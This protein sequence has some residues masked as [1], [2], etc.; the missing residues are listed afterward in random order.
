MIKK[1]NYIFDKIISATSGYE[2]LDI[3]NNQKIDILITDIMMPDFDGLSLSLHAKEKQPAIQIIFITGHSNFEFAKEGINL[4]VLG[5]IVKPISDKEFYKVLD[6]AIYNCLQKTMPV[7]LSSIESALNHIFNSNMSHQSVSSKY[8]SLFPGNCEYRLAV[9]KH[10]PYNE[11]DNIL[12]GNI[13]KTIFSYYRSVIKENSMFFAQNENIN[14]DFMFLAFGKEA[15]E[16]L[17]SHIITIKAM[18]EDA[19]KHKFYALFSRTHSLLSGRLYAEC[20]YAYDQK[21]FNPE[22]TVFFYKECEHTQLLTKISKDISLLESYVLSSNI[23]KIKLVLDSIFSFN[24]DAIRYNIRFVFLVIANSIINVLR[25]KGVFL[26]DFEINSIISCD[27]LT[28]ADKTADISEFFFN[29]IKVHLFE[30]TLSEQSINKLMNEI[31]NYI[32]H[33]YSENLN[34]KKICE[35][36]P[37]SPTYFS[38]LF[39][40]QFGLTFMNFL[41]KIRLEKA[42]YLLKNTNI[43]ISQ[44]ALQVGYSEPQYFHRVFKKNIGIT[45][46]QYRIQDGT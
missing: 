11:T 37:I 40:K 2:A 22:E 20:Y 36:F 16:Q 27:A 35:L 10:R 38:Q 9:L 34:E 29:L 33:Q 41:T 46:L 24:D 14:D 43:R 6:K 12:H 8:G 5:Y 26:S 42:C 3:I 7:K 17:H 28:T 21:L 45:P 13:D 31:K 32:E 18:I 30:I 23:Q 1:Q 39:K 19:T 25:K 15:C 4:G 44:I